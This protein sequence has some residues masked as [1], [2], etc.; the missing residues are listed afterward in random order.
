MERSRK[1]LG[2]IQLK[3]NIIQGWLLYV[4]RSFPP[5][6]FR[7]QY[8]LINLVWLSID[9]FSLNQSRPQ[10][11]FKKLKTS[12]LHSSYSEKMRCGQDWAEASLPAFSWLYIIVCAVV[13]KCQ[14]R[15]FLVLIL[16]STCFICITWNCKQTMK[17]Q[18]QCTC[19]WTK[20]NKNK[21]K[22]KSHHIQIDHAFYCST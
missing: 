5:V 21:N 16:Q 2:T 6:V 15:L 20:S 19:E 14:K 12:F 17:Q 18:L 3:E 8:Q 11:N 1:Y 4:I 22:N 7:F 13:Q 9:L 10:S